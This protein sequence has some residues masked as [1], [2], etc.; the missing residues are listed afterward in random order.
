M[1]TTLSPAPPSTADDRFCALAAEIGRTAREHDAAH[2]RDATFVVEAYRAMADSGYLAMAV[3]RELGGSGATIRQVVCAQYELARWSGSAALAS[4][5]HLYLT[6]LQ[7]FRR[8]AGAADAEAVLTRVADEGIVLA[9][10]GGSDWVCPTT[11][12]TP[13]DGGFLFTGRKGFV[14]Q[15]PVA[16]VLSTSAVL[17]EPGPGAEVLHAGVPMSSPGVTVDETWDTLGMRGTASHDV[18]LADVFVPAAKV[19]G[20]RPYGQLAGPLLLAATYFAPVVSGVYL[21]VAQGAY[22]E[23][24][25]LTAARAEVAP[26]AVRQLGE[27]RARLRVARWAVLGAVDEAGPA[28]GPD[29]AVLA[30]LMTAKRAA[31]LEAVAVTDLALQVVGGPAFARRS[32]LERA[33]RDV[34][35]GPFHPLTPEVT[36][37]TVG[38][39]A[40]REARG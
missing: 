6:L 14:S 18:V 22:D 38:E 34:R 30:T 7:R 29:H 19:A 32:P 20:R 5:M 35:G 15:A 24:L 8:D 1:T 36:L 13:V 3:P 9:T 16:T 26:A 27:M 28:P 39:A 2:D 40:L 23:A 21:G 25:R 12:A 33:Y 10:S 37:Q 17:G 11:T 31:V 4:A